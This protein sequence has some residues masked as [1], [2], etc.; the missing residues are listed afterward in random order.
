MVFIGAGSSSSTV[1]EN[2]DLKEKH[3]KML[4]DMEKQY[5]MS[6]FMTYTT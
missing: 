2:K 4:N 3:E 5:E 1:A 6:R